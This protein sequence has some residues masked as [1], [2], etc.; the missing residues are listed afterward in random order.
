MEYALLSLIVLACVYMAMLNGMNDLSGMVAT[1]IATRAAPVRA[2]QLIAVLGLWLGI[3]VGVAAVSRTVA[4]GL[5][6]EDFNHTHGALALTIWLGAIAGTVAWGTLA[7]QLGIPTS[8][9]HAFVGSL[10]GAVLAATAQP[11][12]VHWGWEEFVRNPTDLH[13]VMKVVAGLILSPVVGG[14]LGYL[15]FRVGAIVLARAS[16]GTAARLRGLECLAVFTQAFSYGTN[17]AQKVMGVLVGALIAAHFVVYRSTDH[18]MVFAVPLWVKL[19]TAVAAT[20]GAFIGSGRIIRTM[21][22]GLFHVHPLE[23]LAGQLASAASVY[24]ASL[25]GAPVSSTQV[26][27]SAL[28]GVGGAW[29]PRHVRWH[30]VRDILMTWVFTPP[31]AGLIGAA[32]T[33]VIALVPGVRS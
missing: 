21:G 13:G 19:L 17:D 30:K 1:L 29:R 10:C 5:I 7:R 31:C 18:S 6:S 27:S 24:G 23:A 28:V 4:T 2:A 14:S 9:T 20:V 22:H 25:T 11:G 15:I 8:A 33:F 3:L 32:V 26:I 16:R 12:L